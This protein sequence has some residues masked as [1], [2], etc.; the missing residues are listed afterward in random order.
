MDQVTGQALATYR[1]IAE[2]EQRAAVSS[3]A[4]RGQALA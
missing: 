1:R 3:E 4:V 2:R